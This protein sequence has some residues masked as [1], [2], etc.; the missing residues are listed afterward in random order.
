MRLKYRSLGARFLL[1]KQGFEAFLK[2]I[3]NTLFN[4]LFK[5]SLIPY[6]DLSWA[7]DPSLR[8]FDML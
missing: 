4:A 2:A 5:Q 7:R 1:F 3:T 8:A 6:I